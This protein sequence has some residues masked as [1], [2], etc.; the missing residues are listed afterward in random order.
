MALASFVLC[1]R[2]ALL[3]SSQEAAQVEN[4]A[5][6][7]I[8]ASRCRNFPE[9]GK[10]QF[11][12]SLGEEELRTASVAAACFKRAEDF[13]YW[14]GNTDDAGESAGMAAVA[15]THDPTSTTQV[16]HA[17]ACDRGWSLW[18]KFCYRHI[19][20]KKNWAEAEACCRDV[21]SGHLVSVHS[22]AE[23]NFVHELTYG[24]SAWIGYTD[25]DKDTHY[26][27]SDSTQDDFSNLAKNCTGREGEADC[28]R[29]S[30]AQQ[31]YNSK[32]DKRLTF[33][34]KRNARLP[35]GLLVN[36]TAAE[37]VSDWAK[38]AGSVS[39]LASRTAAAS[40][41]LKASDMPQTALAAASK[42]STPVMKPLAPKLQTPGLL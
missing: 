39:P 32:G 37:L 20:E 27:W 3:A 9:L 7:T 10:S 1:A 23:N 12:D 4:K 14:C 30:A 26:Q 24:L 8:T 19:W 25:V 11:R 28:T 34:C 5:G 29:E 21:H 31:W 33:V 38:Y 17:A 18:D 2:L 41:T 42:S 22:A 16:Y 40:P 15:A 6:C 36:V 13:Y 35:V